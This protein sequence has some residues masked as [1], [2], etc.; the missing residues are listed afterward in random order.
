MQHRTIQPGINNPSALEGITKDTVLYKYFSCGTFCQFIEKPQLKFLKPTEWDDK[1][2]GHR[3]EFFRKAYQNKPETERYRATCWTLGI[4]DQNCYGSKIEQYKAANEELHEFG[5]AAMWGSYCIGGGV[6]I[7]STYGKL[8]ELLIEKLP[9]GEIWA[10]KVSYEPVS[11]WPSPKST[12]LVGQ[13]FIKGVTFRHESEFRFLFLPDD[14]ESTDDKIPLDI[15]NPYEFIDEFLVAPESAKKTWGAKDLYL[16]CIRKFSP[17]NRKND[18]HHCKI[19]QLYGNISG[20]MQKG[21]M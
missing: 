18:D 19:S 3:Y 5:H 14:Q 6:R 4:D 2:E 21:A 12:G 8:E 7:K 20:E 11:R 16:D 10:G 9:P 13:L 17:S 15:N 1:F